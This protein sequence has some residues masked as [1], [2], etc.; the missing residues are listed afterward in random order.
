MNNY[1]ILPVQGIISVIYASI[2][3]IRFTI[4]IAASAHWKP[5]FPA[6]V[7]ARSI[8]CSMFSVVR[9]P[10]ITGMSVF[11]ATLAIPFDTS[12]HT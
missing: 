8:A 6:F 10:N 11:R 2:S 7:P 5:L 3:L 12:E 1:I 9:T 4:S